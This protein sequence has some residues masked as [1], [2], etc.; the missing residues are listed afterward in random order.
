[1]KTLIYKRYKTRGLIVDKFTFKGYND[2][3][4]YMRL[5]LKDDPELLSVKSV[6]GIE[7]VTIAR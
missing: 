1:M 4:K 3:M 2:L 7:T 5:L 6:D